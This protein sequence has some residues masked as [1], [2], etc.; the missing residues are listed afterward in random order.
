MSIHGTITFEWGGEEHTFRLGLKEVRE[1][2]DNPRVGIGPLALY[3]RIESGDWRVDDCREVIRVGL[4]GGGMKPDLALTK[5]KRY[6]DDFA[7]VDSVPPALTIL[8]AFLVGDPFEPVGKTTA[9]G[10]AKEATAASPSPQSTDLDRPSD[11]HPD[12]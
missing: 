7:A 3:R 11:T 8:G 9:A 6:V 12:R 2:Q 10:D 4:I 5:V 1:L